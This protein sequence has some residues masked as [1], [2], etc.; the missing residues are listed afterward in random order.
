MPFPSDLDTWIHRLS[1]AWSR[2]TSADPEHWTKEDPAH[3]QCAVSAL[4]LQDLFGGELLR[5]EA[6]P[7]GGAPVSHYMNRI[8]G[9]IVD[10]TRGQFPPGTVIGPG[11]PKT[12]GLASTRAY[13]L[14]FPATRVRY[15]LLR[16]LMGL[17][18]PVA[19]E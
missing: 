11:A 16:E 12:G 1:C 2:E 10:A 4:V 5:A 13:V 14:S 7:P 18:G 15:L 3:G 9:R 6:T 19:E 8:D 17:S